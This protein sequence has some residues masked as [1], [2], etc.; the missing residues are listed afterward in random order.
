MPEHMAN[1]WDFFGWRPSDH[2][3]DPFEDQE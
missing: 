2:P 1:T 3:V